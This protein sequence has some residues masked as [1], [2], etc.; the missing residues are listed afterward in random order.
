MVI[1]SLGAR[2]RF[3]KVFALSVLVLF[4]PVLIYFLQTG[5]FDWL[6]KA[7]TGDTWY[8]AVNGSSGGNG[9][10]SSPWDYQSVL[11]G[12]KSSLVGPGDT[13]Y[14]RGGKYGTGGSAGQAL[15][16][17]IG[18][19]ENNY[20]T[21]A[22]YPG[23]QAQIDGGFWI[24][25]SPGWLIIRDFE[26]FNDNV[27]RYFSESGSHPSGF[28]G[29]GITTLVPH[30]KVI[31]NFVHDNGNGINA[32]TAA[33]YFEA[34]GNLVQN[35]GWVGPSDDRAH[36]HGIY[37]QN[38][39]NY[40]KVFRNNVVMPGIDDTGFHLY[41]EEAYINNITLENNIHYTKRWL[42]T[43]SY[44]SSNVKMN[45][46]Y[47]WNSYIMAGGISSTG[48]GLQIT[49]NYSGGKSGQ[50]PLQILYLK[51]NLNKFD[52]SNNVF[53]YQNSS[54]YLIFMYNSTYRSDST[55]TFDNNSLCQAD[56]AN[57]NSS[58]V[59]NS[60][61]K[62]S[63]G[64]NQN[65][66]SANP[67][68]SNKIV[69]IPN[70]YETKRGQIAVYNWQ[71]LNSVSVDISSLGYQVGDAYEIHN[72]ENYFGDTPIRGTYTGS[73]VTI[74][75]SSSRWTI[76]QPLNWQGD[77]SGYSA[78]YNPGSSYPTFG[79]FIIRSSAASTVLPTLTPTTR[80]IATP[81]PTRTISLTPTKTLTP[82]PTRAISL[83]PTR[84]LTPTSSPVATATPVNSSGG[85][86]KFKLA[87]AGV[88]PS[89]QCAQN[90]PV[91]ITVRDSL[92]HS[93]TFS[94]FPLEATTSL[95]NLKTFQGT[96]T[97]QSSLSLNNLSLFIKG[98]R[99]LQVKYGISG[100]NS[101]YLLENG[102]ISVTSNSA[103]TP[104]NDFTGYPLLAG[105]VNNDGWV[106][107]SDFSIVKTAAAK[108]T[109]GDNQITDLNGNCQMESQDLALLM[110]TLRERFSQLY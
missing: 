3:L 70:A 54:D 67:S 33:T 15:K 103:T 107:G 8:V 79:A 59:S 80:L 87:F 18:G 10:I 13:V 5:S 52:I 24:E 63:Y 73:P 93:Q 106:D 23:E 109:S 47:L 100:Q 53:C 94:N 12:S 14:F 97:L 51:A 72:A 25:T 29:N 55:H 36:G 31:N 90:W 95:N 92:G 82:T 34:Y 49:N 7:S 78:R 2:H 83:T 86:L 43:T 102:Q 44:L 105:D 17:N 66:P 45:N 108:R 96:L 110:L 41:G 42:M 48:N 88:N 20:L 71:N 9:S 75:M 37:T 62:S 89:A 56:S 22:S 85:V 91:T 61:L 60:T 46:N 50:E 40:E 76:A 21:L 16:I 39:T 32:D 28:P 35:N 11:G 77:R 4:L 1:Y 30:V 69:V 65:Q 6:S 104:V 64:F 84:T 81:T 68:A 101:F 38:G 74:D 99:H 27:S 57:I 58:R 98:P 19:S 26:I